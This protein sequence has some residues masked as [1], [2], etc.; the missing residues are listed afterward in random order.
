MAP[1]EA[2][3]I[4]ESPGLAAA[5]RMEAQAGVIQLTGQMGVWAAIIFQAAVAVLMALQAHPGQM[6]A[7]EAGRTHGHR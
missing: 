3:E 2:E 6:A 5:V 4:P 1:M 7:V